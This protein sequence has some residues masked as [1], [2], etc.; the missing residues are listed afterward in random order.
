MGVLNTSVMLSGIVSLFLMLAGCGGGGGGGS[1]GNNGGLSS[2]GGSYSISIDKASVTFSATTNGDGPESVIVKAQFKGDG[3][4]V[5]Y[6][7][8]VPEASWL[9]VST[10]SS[11]SN[12]ATFELTAFPGYSVKNYST[13][14]RFVTGKENG[15]NLKY[16]ELPISLNVKEGFS[17]GASVTQFNFQS[18]GRIT[19]AITPIDYQINIKGDDSDWKISSD[20]W[21]T[22]DKNSGKGSSVVKA[23]INPTGANY[24]DNIGKITVT[25]SVSKRSYDFNVHYRLLH[26]DVSV[27]VKK[28]H[29]SIDENTPTS[30]LSSSFVVSDSLQGISEENIF[31][32]SFV[33]SSAD[34]VSLEENSGTTAQGQAKPKIVIDK[35]VL[36]AKS[37]GENYKATVT[38]KTQSEFSQATEYS[39]DVEAFIA[40]EPVAVLS[41]TAY[42]L[43]YDV[44][45]AAF[46]PV[47]KQLFLSD[48]DAKKLY[49]VDA[50]TGK[51]T[52][53]YS[54]EQMP[55]SLSV[56]PNGKYLFVALLIHE[57]N[58]YQTNPGGK[59]AVIDLNKGSVVN[60]FD[61]NL[62]PWDLAGTDTADIYVSAGSG[63]WTFLNRYKG[64]TG[65]L[66]I[67]GSSRHRITLTLSPD[68]QSVY[69]VTTDL[70]PGDISHYTSQ[71]YNNQKFLEERNS[72][73][74]GEYY[75]GDRV[76]F[77]PSGNALIT[78]WGNMF[79]TDDLTFIRQVPASNIQAKALAF[80]TTNNR[81]LMI[82][83]EYYGD[84]TKMV[85][86]DL[87]NYDN[88]QIV[89]TDA[90]NGEFIFVD[91]GTILLIEK[92]TLGFQLQKL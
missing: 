10:V 51:T 4:I 63:Q 91:E 75:I 71:T 29:F 52:H 46:S 55:E 45:R 57:H 68:Q 89:K 85:S 17:A 62:D 84:P 92:T 50:E 8:N 36:L 53:Y 60:K 49:V 21:I 64:L 80:D 32:W 88:Y 79:K 90:E 81:L 23:S 2:G 3:V 18:T 38:F 37:K 67:S 40:Q 59:V 43:D 27:D 87:P 7:P 31:T 19:S 82:E 74:H 70:S 65:E 56:S 1:S 41:G 16:V 14:L 33:S 15:T 25:D 58:Y 22:V 26:A 39:I 54:F 66:D 72:P 47:S 76:W 44:D 42:Q 6:P 78:E 73:Y 35:N 9:S 86:Y 12:S 28:H 48:R 30:E 34:W 5:G 83:R 11:T 69:S 20:S 13:T 77:E 24:G 61:T